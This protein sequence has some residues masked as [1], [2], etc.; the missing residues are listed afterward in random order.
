MAI[1]YT[2]SNLC[3]PF[4]IN[5]TGRTLPRIQVVEHERTGR[6][7]MRHTSRGSV[8]GTVAGALLAFLAVGVLAPEARAGCSHY[9]LSR[10]AA[11][12][13]DGSGLDLLDASD[14]GRP[15]VPVERPKPCSGVFCSGNPGLPDLPTVSV[16][17]RPGDWG[18]LSEPTTVPEAD[19]FPRH[20]DDDRLSPSHCGSGVF[21]PPRAA[22]GV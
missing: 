13:R 15:A 21:H 4:D 9:V 22:S 1:T 18:L 7:V 20:H 12:E 3:G 8:G 10:H 19:S 5:E 17:T 11:L 16:D 2:Q 14:T 6:G